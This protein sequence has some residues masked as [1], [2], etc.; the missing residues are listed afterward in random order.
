MRNEVHNCKSVDL[1][2][3]SQSHH[4]PI[5]VD[6][7]LPGTDN[8]LRRHNII[9]S[10]DDISMRVLL[11]LYLVYIAIR[12][13]VL[14]SDEGGL[15]CRDCPVLCIY[16]Q[17]CCDSV[18]MWRCH[19]SWSNFQHRNSLERDARLPVIPSNT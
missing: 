6:N 2:F 4:Q 5:T 19:L 3:F 13:H 1:R 9:Q 12:L 7:L 10:N 15:Q 11:R 18:I 8:S 17:H 16:M 14:G